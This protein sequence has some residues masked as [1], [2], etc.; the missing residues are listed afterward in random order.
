[1]SGSV[2]QLRKIT[3]TSITVSGVEIESKN[4]LRNLGCFFYAEMKMHDYVQDILKVGYYQLSQLKVLRRCLTPKTTNTLVVSLVLSKLDYCNSLLCGIPECLI[5]KLQL[6]QNACARFVTGV[7]KYDHITNAL[8]KLHWLSIESRVKYKI[9][10]WVYKCLNGQ[11]LKYL[12]SLLSVRQSR[13][14]RTV[15]QLDLTVPRTFRMY[16]GDRAFAVAGPALW[17]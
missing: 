9:M 15:S 3:Y 5:K 1:M 8:R 14:R 17:N 10:L 2:Q 13:S 12:S 16:G 6:L 7:K 11:T 4:S